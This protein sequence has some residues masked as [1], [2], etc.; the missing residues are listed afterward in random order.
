[1]AEVREVDGPKITNR[2]DKRFWTSERIAL[3]ERNG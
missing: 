3:I 2:L 1:V